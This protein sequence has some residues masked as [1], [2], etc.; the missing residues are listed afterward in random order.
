MESN[1]TSLEKTIL[2]LSLIVKE[3]ILGMSIYLLAIFM[4]KIN[5]QIN[6]INGVFW[7]VLINYIF[8]K[9]V[10]S[11]TKEHYV[12]KKKTKLISYTIRITFIVINLVGFGINIFV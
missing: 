8:E 12:L 1:L 6:I 9:F 11:G 5:N 4:L 2:L 7:M 3:Y 10:L